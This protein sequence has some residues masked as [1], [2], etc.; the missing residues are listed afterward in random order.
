MATFSPTTLYSREGRGLDT[1]L[2]NCQTIRFREPPCWKLASRCRE[3]D[4]PGEGMEAPPVLHPCISSIWL[5]PNCT[6]YHKAVIVRGPLSWVLWV[7]LG[8]CWT[9]AGLLRT[10]GKSVSRLFTVFAS[11][12]WRGSSLVGPS[13]GSVLILGSYCQNEIQ[14]LDASKCQRI[15]Q[16]AKKQHTWYQKN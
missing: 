10:V 3:A 9:C 1:G 4:A 5:F 6:L 2:Q 16:F 8:N 11:D 15:T 13:L 12:I 14:L 7:V